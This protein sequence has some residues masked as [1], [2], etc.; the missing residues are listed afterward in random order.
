MRIAFL[1]LFPYHFL[2]VL[3]MKF[4][5]HTFFFHYHGSCSTMNLSEPIKQRGFRNGLDKKEFFE[6]NILGVLCGLF[7]EFVFVELCLQ[8]L[9]QSETA[10][11]EGISEE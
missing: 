5:S 8:G 1:A 9:G 10:S 3:S 4:Y 7:C 6:E 2:G 11:S